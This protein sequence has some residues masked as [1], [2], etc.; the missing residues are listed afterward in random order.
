MYGGVDVHI[1][2]FLAS[3]LIG[4]QG[5]APCPNILLWG[6]SLQYQQNRS[7][8]WYRWCGENHTPI[9]TWAPMPQPSNPQPNAT[10]AT[11][12]PLAKT[13]ARGVMNTYCV[14]AGR[15]SLHSPLCRPLV[16]YIKY[17]HTMIYDVA[18]PYSGY[19]QQFTWDQQFHESGVIYMHRVCHEKGCTLWFMN[20]IL[21]NYGQLAL[22][23]NL[24]P[25]HY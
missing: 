12:P 3:A 6:K 9:G 20:F 1:H 14:L 24:E 11:L 13:N 25:I 23:I 8:N 16:H 21:S 5:S 22:N 17:I 15:H 19:M 4:G 2:I 18:L 7:Q 10:A